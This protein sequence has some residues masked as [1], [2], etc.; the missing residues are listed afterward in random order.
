MSFIVPELATPLEA[1]A[2][3]LGIGLLIGMERERRPDSA[4]G[5][6]TFALT[7]MLGC[8]FALLGEKAGGPWMLAVG[9]LVIAASMVAS[10]FSAQQEE[11]YRGFTSEAAIIVT[12]GLGAA[13]WYGYATLAVMLAITTTVL[14]YFKAEMRQVSERMTPKD[15]NSILQ[16]AVLSLVI[17]PIL[18]NQDFGPYNALN[19]R[20]I[21]WMV[22]LISGL[23]LA[24]YL[25]LRIVGARHGAA[26]LGIFGGLASSTA[27]TLMFSRHAHE[28]GHLVRMA[29][30]VILIANVMVMIRLGLVSGM[31]APTLITPIAIVFACGIVPGIIVA[32]YGW[33]ALSA[34]G[35]LPMP[36]VKNPTELKTAI[37]F[38]LLYAL[39]VLASAWLQDI[40]GNKGLYIVALASGLTDADASVLSTLRLFNLQKLSSSEAVIAVT[41]ALIANL[42]FKIGL[43]LSIGGSKLARHALPGLLAIGGGL[44]AGLLLI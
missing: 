28:L 43:V 9:L 16:F 44:A 31:V 15:I 41:L 19:P 10:N 29:A 4:A 38:G 33:K 1:F 26:L 14:L 32:L 34:A 37:S 24:G 17:L 21:W 36:E 23:A 40:A 7:S 6:R 13:I 42:V 20:Q 18:P 8:L 11:Q 3:A 25:A 22:V 27:T 2:T 30:T 35:E 12:Y 5:L 39:V